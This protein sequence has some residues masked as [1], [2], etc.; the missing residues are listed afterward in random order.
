MNTKSK[1]FTLTSLLFVTVVGLAQRPNFA[2][3]YHPSSFQQGYS[4]YHELSSEQV[5]ELKS[6]KMQ[7]ALDLDKDENNKVFAIAL[8]FSKEMREAIKTIKTE[9]GKPSPETIHKIQLKK[10]ELLQD[11]KKELK[12]FLSKDK[13]EK[14]TLIMT[15]HYII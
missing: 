3:Q 15:K 6:K 2:N 12:S 11:I 13:V 9:S 8:K 14:W 5:A 10:L 1:I 4:L 7:L